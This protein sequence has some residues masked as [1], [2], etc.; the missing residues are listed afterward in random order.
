MFNQEAVNGILS[1]EQQIAQTQDQL[2][3]GK[4]INS[5]ADNPVG[6]VQ[7]LQLDTVNSQNTQYISNGQSANTNL[8]LEEQALS[9]STTTLQSI[10][11]LVV[12]ANSG[13]NNASDL[14]NIATQISQ[15]ESQLQGVAN[16]QN[17]QGQY[18][19]AGFSTSTQ[20]FVRSA[21]GAMS[22]VGDSG[23]TSV[24]I[25]G[26][27]SVQSGD[28][29]SSVF[30][31]IPGGNG[32]FATAAASAN[33]GTGVVDAGSVTNAAAF[34]PPGQY[35]I[36]FTGPTTYN[37]TDPTGAPVVTG[38]TYDPTQGSQI[39]FNGVEV[40]ITGAPAAGD[41]FTVTPSTKTSVFDTL[42]NLVNALNSTGSG[43]AAKARLASQ[44]GGALQNIDQSLNQVSNVSASVGSRIDLVSSVASTVNTDSTTVSE[45]IS[46]IND[47]D[48][49][50]ASAQYS[51]E[52]VALQAAEQSYAAV[53]GLSLFKFLPGG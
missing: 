53:D 24:A 3:T 15:L 30:M 36:T 33:T 18:L 16:S 26:G 19:F 21:T 32:T 46:N 14:Q 44:L 34:T 9:S 27:T 48:Y 8:T 11:D 5:P 22:Y 50:K 23:S 43:S 29:G 13:T 47:L 38:G 35:T 10:R 40:G 37:V 45:Q 31:N 12:E 20:P 28:P 1:A 42:D 4:N 6:E 52:I 17:A 2:S 49:A 39:S 51:Q 7:L 41:S 25:N